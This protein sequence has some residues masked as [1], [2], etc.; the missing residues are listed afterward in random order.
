MN[1]GQSYGWA[2]LLKIADD[3]GFTLLPEGEYEAVVAQ[4]EVK[5]TAENN[6]SI[7]VTFQ[8]TSGPEAGRKARK[9]L[10][11]NPDKPGT[12]GF[13]FRHITAL[14]VTREFF[15]QVPPPSIAQVAQA[16][17]N[18]PCRITVVHDTY[19]GQ[20]RHQVASITESLTS[21]T[22]VPGVPTPGVPNG[23]FSPAVPVPYNYPS[24]PAAVPPPIVGIP[25][26]TAEH[27]GGTDVFAADNNSPSVAPP[28]LPF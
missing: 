12:I 21:G 13:F 11:L 27:P 2:D 18:R 28:E 24:S 26:V 25:P 1:L 9:T 10:T 4:T 3:A 6:D 23:P 20:K 5:Q 19:G 7:A 17:M 15:Q 22:T 8:I 16:I 14:G